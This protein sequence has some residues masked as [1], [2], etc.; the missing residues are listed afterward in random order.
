MAD[1]V[2]GEPT[3]GFPSDDAARAAR[4]DADFQRAVVAY[5]F[6]YPTVSAEG[7]FNG[8][9][10]IGIADNEAIG[11]AFCGPRQ[12]GF[13]LNSDTPYG[14]AALDLSAG[15]IVIELPAGPYI[16]LVND[17]HQR[18]ITDMGIPG[19]DAGAGGKYVI[20][21][22]GFAGTIPADCHAAASATLKVL[23]A[24]R[25]MPVG[26]DVEAALQSLR[27]IT[28]H[29]LNSGTPL[30]VV[31]ITDDRIDSTCLR[32][33]DGIEFWRILHEVLDY[34]PVIDEFR[35]MH[36]L[37]AA[38]G[39]GKCQ[40][41]NPDRRMT[42][43]LEQAAQ[44]GRAQLLVSAFASTRADRLA[45]NDRHWEWLGLVPADAGFETPAGIDLE[46]RDR[47]FAQAIVTS[48]AMFRRQVGG[49][50]LYWLAARDAAG[51]FLD[52]SKC[53]TLTLPLPVPATL[54][55]SVTIYDAQTRS[56]VQADQD[57]AAL[58]SLFELSST[59]AETGS[60][61]LY[62]GPH[63]HDNGTDRWLQTVPGR[64]WF[65]YIRIYGPEQDAFDGQW[66][67]GD[68]TADPYQ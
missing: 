43:I 52:G 48:P 51:E 46:A 49:G 5:R 36:G 21:P 19:P 41:F 44:Q 39:L 20:T 59:T 55:W 10:E 24:V 31:D 38:L 1:Q 13:T 6:W 12:V 4:D 32:W 67:P 14:S 56:Q 66:R 23:L 26:G 22:P 64:G 27:S 7:I 29:P 25:A 58:R 61:T 50:S 17:H 9:R 63:E 16:G 57:K 2:E 3:A 65:A 15:P 68:L 33:E 62:F 18:W 28:I 47:W 40:P 53:Y 45:W 30:D 8:N 11:I 34:E 54:F 35:P 42:R 37:L 60:T